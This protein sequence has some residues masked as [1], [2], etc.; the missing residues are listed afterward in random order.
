MKEYNNLKI[1]PIEKETKK[2]YKTNTKKTW[3]KYF[4]HKNGTNLIGNNTDNKKK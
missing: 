1:Y 3:N 2:S 4:A